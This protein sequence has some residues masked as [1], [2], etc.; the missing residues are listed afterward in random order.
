MQAAGLKFANESIELSPKL[1]EVMGLLERLRLHLEDERTFWGCLEVMVV[2]LD[3][4]DVNFCPSHACPLC[5]KGLKRWFIGVQTYTVDLSHLIQSEPITWDPFLI[6]E[7]LRSYLDHLA[8]V[9]VELP[10]ARTKR[11]KINASST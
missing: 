6:C 8:S 9:A 2:E 10:S 7:S 4:N 3:D 5:I 11:P 1:R